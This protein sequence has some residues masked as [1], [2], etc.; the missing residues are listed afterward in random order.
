MIYSCKLCG[1]TTDKRS[2]IHI[3]HIKPRECGGSNAEY[4]KVMVCPKC[5]SLIYSRYATT[6][7]HSIK[8][9]HSIEILGWRDSTKGRILECRNLS[10][11]IIYYV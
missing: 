1:Y 10:T 7:I 8:G 9:K 3:H 2:Q 11:N 4:N 5:H 6:G